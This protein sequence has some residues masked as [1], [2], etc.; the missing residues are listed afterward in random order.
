MELVS[1]ALIQNL[2]CVACTV[3]AQ[4]AWHPLRLENAHC[5]YP[6]KEM[7]NSITP[8]KHEYAFKINFVVDKKDIPSVP[9]LFAEVIENHIHNV[10]EI[11]SK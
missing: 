10:V 8:Y 11:K 4:S 2:V 9:C 3:Y 5:A 1:V 6:A 7:L